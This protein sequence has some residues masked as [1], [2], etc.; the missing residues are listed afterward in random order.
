[1]EKSIAVLKTRPAGLISPTIVSLQLAGWLLF[2][3]LWLPL[4]RGCGGSDKIPI[5]SLQPISL[6]DVSGLFSNLIVLGS[7]S[8]GLIVA[9]AMCIAAW[10]ASERL[11]KVFFLTQFIITAVGGV[12]VVAFGIVHSSNGKELVESSLGAIPP[13]VGFLIWVG[14]A[15]R[16]RQFP[17]AWARLQH[18]WTIVAL[19]FVHLSMLFQGTVLYGYWLTMI[20]LGGLVIAVELAKYR[21]AHDLWLATKPVERPQFSIRRIL[22]WTAFFPFVFSYYRAIDPF[23]NWLFKWLIR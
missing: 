19:F 14:I 23:C 12:V 4:C 21:M 16:R 6:T 13:L 18:A 3:C 8:N 1:M 15:I 11:W 10:F 17:I 22:V 9:L 20:G 2:I 5:N 7:Y